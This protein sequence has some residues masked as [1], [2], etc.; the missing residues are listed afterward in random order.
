MN[1]AEDI[2]SAVQERYA[3]AARNVSSCC[4]PAACSDTDPFGQSQYD[5]S[6]RTSLPHEAVTA[7]LGCGNP[8]LLA[9]LKPGDVV[10]DLGSGGGIDV[11][12][13]ARRVAPDGMAYGLDMTPEMLE[14]ANANK[15]KAGVENVEFLLGTIEDIPLPDDSVDVIISNCVVN[16]S[17]DKGQ[18][19]REAFRVLRPG[20][21][22]AISDVVL[23]R[24][25]TPELTAVMALWTGCITGALVE[26]EAIK[27]MEAAG[28]EQVSIEPT[29]VFG[30]SELEGLASGLSSEDLAGVGDLGSLVADFDGVIRSASLRGTK[31]GTLA[32][33]P[34]T[35]SREIHVHSVRVYEPALCCNTGVCGEDVDQ[36]L[37][38]FSAD[39][40]HLTE[41]GAD[42]ARHNLANDPLAFAADESV[43]GFL[44][45]AGSEGLPLTTVDGVTVLTGTYPTRD[46]LLRYT[47]L[48]QA[49]VVPAGAIELTV[50]ESTGCGST[51]CC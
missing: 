30:R 11:L 38:E 42:I 45:V 29:N 35:E 33:R 16:L 15:A 49:P 34:A 17:V 24:P 3:D 48:T 44:E 5:D 12:L 43:R 13:S 32:T 26:E 37:V 20:G 31:P 25:L 23:S 18:V 47:G 14:L 8:T 51:G 21:R 28:F 4:G 6:D 10:L 9:A 22:L 39:L 41:Q 7:S 50:A 27:L 2:R 46:Q 1:Q 40:N 36:R 19:F